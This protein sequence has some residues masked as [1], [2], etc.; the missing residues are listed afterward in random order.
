MADYDYDLFT[1][2]AGSGGVRAS[3]IAAGFGARVAVAE[4]RDL[5]GTC[6]NVGCV[7]KKLFVYA[8]HYAD[9]FLDSAGFG[10]Q[11]GTRSFNWGTLIAN[12]DREIARLNAIYA[13]LLDNAGVERMTGRARL[14]DPHT[15][16]IGNRT[17][18]SN[19]ILLATGGWPRRPE[20]P[21]IE[22]AITSNEAF[23]LPELPKRIVIVGGGYI[24]VEFAGI[25][26]N[27]GVETTLLYR[28]ELFMRGFDIDIRTTLRDAMQKRGIKLRFAVNVDTISKH[29]NGLHI[30]L[31]DG[32]TQVSDQIMFAIGRVPLTRDLGLE[33]CGVEMEPDGTVRVDDFSQTSVPNIHAIGDITNRINLTPVAI[34][35]AMAFANTVFNNRPTRPQYDNVPSAVFSQPPIA[36]VGLTDDEATT[37]G[38]TIDVYRSRFRAMRH[39]L[40]GR[41]EQTMMKLVVDRVTDRVLGLH[42]V[43]PDAG[44]IVQGFAVA[45]KAGA[46]KSVFDATVGIHP[47]AAEEFV[48]MREPVQQS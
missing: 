38:H 30:A 2:G 39:T 13:R 5:G 27:L 37:A 35:E 34:A 44:E 25:F 26:N 4:E 36:T 40:S 17:R 16:Q 29:D 7:P 11:L 24:A 46:T 18:T 6:V 22:H 14:L 12:K 42:M 32:T 21:G 41:D 48:T 1:I 33:E 45:L 15:I 23:S 19:H 20:I 28:G 10:W 43:G 31:T 9:D 47:T 3:R 8:S